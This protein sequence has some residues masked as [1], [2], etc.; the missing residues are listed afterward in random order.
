MK[1]R[2]SNGLFYWIGCIEFAT[3]YVY[4]ASSAAGPW[5]KRA[6]INNCYYD[7]GLLIDDDDTLYVAFGNTNIS[8]AQLS[9]DGFTQVKMQ[10]VFASPSSIG[11]IEG[12]RFYKIN[13]NYIILVTQPAGG[14]WALK[15][16]TGPFGPYTSKSFVVGYGNPVP[17]GGT[18]HQGGIVDT[19]SGQWYYMGFVDSYPGGRIPVMGPVT[20]G[21]DGFPAFQTVNNAFGTSYPYPMGAHPLASHTGTDSFAGSSLGPEWEW[22]HNPDTTKFSVSNGLKLQTATVT[23]DLYSARNTLT[24]R[25]LG[26]TSTATIILDYSSMHDGDRAG[27]AMLRDQSSWIG[28]RRDNGTVRLTRV[29][30]INM[31]TNWNTSNTGSEIASGPTLPTSGRVWLRVGADIRPSTSSHAAVFGYSTDG[32]TFVTLGSTF[33]MDTSWQFFM[34]YRFAILNYATSALGGSVTVDSFTLSTP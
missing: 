3:T 28:V 34:G 1:Y 16:T 5:T 10:Q 9:S 29:S 2:K 4:T 31:D 26:P 12:S 11:T 7:V 33:T 19:P 25:I 18:P 22:N 8:V 23:A 14:E 15:S 24:R 20:W 30:N 13:G 21:S 6:T 27:L 32:N 17:G